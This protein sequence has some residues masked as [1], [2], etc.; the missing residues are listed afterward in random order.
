MC[1]FFGRLHALEVRYPPVLCR[2]LPRAAHAY[3]VSSGILCQQYKTLLMQEIPSNILRT[4]VTDGRGKPSRLEIQT[5]SSSPTIVM[6]S[7]LS[8]GCK[9]RTGDTPGRNLVVCIDGTSN[10]FGDKNTNI[11]HLCGSIIKNNQQSVCYL[12]GVGTHGRPGGLRHARFEI[13]V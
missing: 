9:C 5:N 8:P 11:V 6:S 2:A 12:T 13:R 1:L 4:P 10:K 7:D 3:I